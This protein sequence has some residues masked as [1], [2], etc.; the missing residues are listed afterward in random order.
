MDASLWWPDKD[1]LSDEP[2]SM[3][4]RVTVPADRYA[5]SDGH[6]RSISKREEERCYEWFVSYPINNYNVSLNIGRYVHLFDRYETGDG[7]HLSL[8]YYV[9]EGNQRIA[10]RHF[11][12]VKNVLAYLEEDLGPYSFIRDGF[13]LI[14]TPYIDHYHQQL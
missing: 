8:D 11:A 7:Q 10:E 3:S 1:R 2:D 12:Q 4:I 5:I 9:L 6:L 14:E 13:A